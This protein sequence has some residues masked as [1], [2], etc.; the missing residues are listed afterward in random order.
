MSK[1]QLRNRSARRPS[2]SYRIGKTISWN[3]TTWGRKTC[4]KQD[5]EGNAD[6]ISNVLNLAKENV[7]S[8]K[9]P[10]MN[11]IKSKQAKNDE[12]SVTCSNDDT[13]LPADNSS[14]TRGQQR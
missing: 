8:F 7:S 5:G 11:D 2:S 6:Y 1:K 3:P 12:P 10:H 9:W 13:T 4:P 14:F